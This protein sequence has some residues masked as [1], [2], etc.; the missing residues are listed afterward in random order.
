M[1]NIWTSRAHP[2]LS[3]YLHRTHDE[4]K[5]T[6]FY[7]HYCVENC[8]IVNLYLLLGAIERRCMRV[9][10]STRFH[11]FREFSGVFRLNACFPG[12]NSDCARVQR[13]EELLPVEFPLDFCGISWRWEYA[14]GGGNLELGQVSDDTSSV[15][16]T[17]ITTKCWTVFISIFLDLGDQSEENFY[18][19]TSGRMNG[20]WVFLK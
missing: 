7:Q 19:F 2:V 14:A 1:L 4:E 18:D 11:G 17:T 6:Q 12:A 13:S 10:F 3:I 9:S 8:Q 20:R 16:S 5:V 15:Q